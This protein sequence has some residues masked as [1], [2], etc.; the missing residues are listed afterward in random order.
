MHEDISITV[1]VG[2]TNAGTAVTIAVLCAVWI[3]EVRVRLQLEINVRAVDEEERDG[4]ATRDDEQP[5][6][7]RL[8]Y[9]N[10]LHQLSRFVAQVALTLERAVVRSGNHEC[11]GDGQHRLTCEIYAGAKDSLMQDKVMSWAGQC[12]SARAVVREQGTYRTRRLRGGDLELALAA[13]VTCCDKGAAEDKQNIRKDGAKHLDRTEI[14]K[15]QQH[16]TRVHTEV[17]TM[18]ISSAERIS[19]QSEMIPTAYLGGGRPHRR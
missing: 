15:S 5:A 4:G 7:V 8:V 10:D 11:C 9:G 2:G 6:H 18:R 13:L 1:G 19:Q 12:Q 3:E 14:R 17:W 16:G